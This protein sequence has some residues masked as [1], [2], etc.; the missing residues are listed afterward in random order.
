M[1]GDAV[2][3]DRGRNAPHI[4]EVVRKGARI[5]R[6]FTMKVFTRDGRSVTKKLK[7]RA[8]RRGDDSGGPLGC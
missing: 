7:L 4:N 3:R 2:I 1:S 5:G 6:T 8:E